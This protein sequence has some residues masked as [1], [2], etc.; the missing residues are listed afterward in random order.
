ML[1]DILENFSDENFLVADGFNAAV[2]GFDACTSR[3][4]YSISKC[5]DILREG[6]G[7]SYEDAIEYFDYNVLSAYM[8]ENTPI[9]SED[10]F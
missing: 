3:L 2:I 5:I 4:I 9:W 6:D 10:R 1:E 7:M 8:G